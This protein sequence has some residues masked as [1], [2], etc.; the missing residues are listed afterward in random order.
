VVVLS[1]ATGALVTAGVEAGIVLV[2]E[3]DALADFVPVLEGE[4]GTQ[5]ELVW[6]VILGSKS[7]P[8]RII[9]SNLKRIFAKLDEGIL[10]KLQLS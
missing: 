4:K 9:S 3:D 5:P 1:V 10:Q 6:A 7:K 2:A 8:V